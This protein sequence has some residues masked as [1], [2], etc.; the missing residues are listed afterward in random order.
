[1]NTGPVDPQISVII[2]HYNDPVRLELCLDELM[3]NNTEG[4]EIIV[5]DNASNMSLDKVKSKHPWVQF[6]AEPAKGA[7]LARNAGVAA[8]RAPTLAFIDADCVPDHDWLDAVR[9]VSGQADVTGGRVTVFDE[10]PPPRSGP[11]AFEAVFAFDFKSYIE[12]KGFSG[13]G[14]LV[15]SRAVFDAV[16]PFVNGVSEDTEWT[17]RAVAMGYRLAYA[18]EMRVGHPSR[19]D[20][21]ALK[22]KWRRIVQESYALARLSP[23]GRRRWALRALM[24][25]ASIVAHVPRVLASPALKGAGERWR[26]TT[27]MAQ[28]RVLRMAWMLRQAIGQE[29]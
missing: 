7:A 19:Q 11:E 25:P 10:T 9:M 4:A 8:S 27:T 14:N 20:W 16:G 23:G 28:L 6:I 13:S 15:T 24:M 12:K 22:R 1:M 26:A 5:V 29:I 18:D 2:P 3:Q 17:M 21:P